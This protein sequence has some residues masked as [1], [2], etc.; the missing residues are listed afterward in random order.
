MA[1]KYHK[2]HDI[3]WEIFNV[4]LLMR[5]DQPHDDLVLVQK[6]IKKTMHDHVL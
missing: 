3:I 6:D 4:T 2:F 5:S 1:C